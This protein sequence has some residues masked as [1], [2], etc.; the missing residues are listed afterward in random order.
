M[1]RFRRTV[2]FLPVYKI[3]SPA[4]YLLLAYCLYW[5]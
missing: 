3:S 1:K 4:Y 5:R 2:I